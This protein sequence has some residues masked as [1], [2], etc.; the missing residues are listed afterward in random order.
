MVFVA[1]AY[2]NFTTPEVDASSVEEALRWRRQGFKKSKKSI[3][4]G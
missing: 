2:F 4:F 1:I 3:A